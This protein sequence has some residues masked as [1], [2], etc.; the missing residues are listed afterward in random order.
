VEI[1]ITPAVVDWLNNTDP[2]DGIALV[3][4]GGLYATFDSKENTGTS[5]LPELDIVFVGGVSSVTTPNGSGLMGG[6]TGNVS[7]SLT[8]SC[9]INQ[10]LSYNGDEWVCHTVS[11]S[12]GGTVTSVGSGTGLTGGPITTSGTLSVDPNVVPLLSLEN[13]FT[14]SQ[15]VIGS[16][17]A[18]NLGA[19]GTVTAGGG[20]VL[21]ASGNSQTSGSPSSPLD[22]TASASN[23]TNAS[24]QTFR[25]QA[26]NADGVTPSANLDLLF[27]SAGATP[28]ATG[29]SIAPNGIIT[30]A[31]NQNF[32]GATGAQG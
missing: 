15:S 2:N 23:G 5:H 3:P 31:P 18:T 29:L 16:L 7:L 10:V 11:G 21:P 12:G 1:D 17:T 30:F 4:N 32:P 8:N 27:G 22:L 6:G 14:A 26:V 24:N 9:N 13:Q 25:W 19:S 20:A 28:A